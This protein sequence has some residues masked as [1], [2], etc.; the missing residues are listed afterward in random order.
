MSTVGLQKHMSWAGVSPLCY[1]VYF[2]VR[3][4]GIELAMLR[5]EH[6]YFSWLAF[7]AVFSLICL[8]MASS[9]LSSWSLPL[10]PRPWNGSLSYLSSVQ[11]QSVVSLVDQS[12]WINKG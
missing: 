10:T 9:L 4:P 7:T 12:T 8:L 2:P 11:P 5:L 6:S 3:N 1:L